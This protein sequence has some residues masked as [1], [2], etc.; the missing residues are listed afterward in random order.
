VLYKEIHKPRTR[1]A[2]KHWEAAGSWGSGAAGGSR[3][4]APAAK[5]R[6]TRRAGLAAR[7]AAPHIPPCLHGAHL[8]RR[9]REL[10]CAPFAWKKT[11][12]CYASSA[13]SHPH[14]S[15]P[16][17]LKMTLIAVMGI[18]NIFSIQLALS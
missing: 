10:R 14:A 9:R 3:A 12:Q 18:N 4:G 17:A 6:A 5:C 1:I 15:P 16:I 7:A 2:S 13:T 11:L 8:P